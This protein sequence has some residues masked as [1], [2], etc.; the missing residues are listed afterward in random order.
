M[1]MLPRISCSV[2]LSEPTTNWASL[3]VPLSLNWSPPIFNLYTAIVR[4]RPT[5]AKNESRRDDGEKE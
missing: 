5:A 3:W 1:A 4:A 2:K